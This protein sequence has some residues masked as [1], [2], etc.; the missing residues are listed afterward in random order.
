MSPA[1]EKPGATSVDST[2]DTLSDLQMKIA[3]F[4]VNGVA[5]RM[6]RLLE[7]LEESK[8]DVACLQE[9]K[10]GD[11]TFPHEPIEAAGYQVIWH[12]MP[13][14]HGVAIL[15]RQGVPK[16]IRRG[17]P[18]DDSDGQARYLEADVAG[19]RIA[20]VYL[21]NGNPAP[22]PN[23]DY[24]LRWMKRFI[25]HAA[26]LVDRAGDVVLCGDFNVVPT[27]NDI[28]N[29]GSWRFDAVLQPQTRSLWQQLLAQGWVDAARHVHPTERR[30]AYTYWVDADAYARGAGFRMDF[31]LLSPRLVDRLQCAEV[32][33]A[34]RARRKPSDHA[35]VWIELDWHT[36]AS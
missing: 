16:E 19:L 21:P 32:D 8:P 1:A 4:N 12:G 7:W 28:Y 26:T 3:T 30:G 20:S 29:A 33:Q 6:P 17:L 10:T 13:R 2:G 5:G 25:D 22:S 27:N 11:P 24:K 36:A 23:F 9:I 31:V 15:S 18:G 34:Y 14:F 35:P